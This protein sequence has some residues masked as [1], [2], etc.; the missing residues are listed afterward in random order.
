MRFTLYKWNPFTL[1][2]RNIRTTSRGIYRCLMIILVLLHPGLWLCPTC[3][4]QRIH[5]VWWTFVEANTK[6]CQAHETW[7]EYHCF[8]IQTQNII[9][10]LEMDC[11]SNDQSMRC[12]NSHH[13]ELQSGVWLKTRIDIQKGTAFVVA[14]WYL[15]LKSAFNDQITGG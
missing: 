8:Q 2:K 9:S 11:G 6:H 13:T 4:F 15:R 14:S 3:S 12:Q 7:L 5:K 10:W 1:V